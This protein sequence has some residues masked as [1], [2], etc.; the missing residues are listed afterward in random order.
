M[1]LTVLPYYA[2][3]LAVMYVVLAGLVVRQRVKSRV[4]L[5]DGQQPALVKAVRI[6]G[7]FAE[8]VPLLLILLLVLEIQGAAL[9][10][11]HLVGG[12]TVFGRVSHAIGLTKTSGTSL[13]R[14]IGMISTFIAL[15]SS[16]AFLVLGQ[17]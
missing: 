9:W 6:H 8:Y 17:A 16:A 3:A 4:G 15:L 1:T 13:P 7:N 10:Q 5:G 11:L 12:L 2:A 14:M